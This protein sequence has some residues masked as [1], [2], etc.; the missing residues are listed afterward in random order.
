MYYFRKDLV[1]GSEVITQEGKA[2][3]NYIDTIGKCCEVETYE[4]IEEDDIY[5]YTGH[6]LM[7]FSDI[8]NQA[9]VYGNQAIFYQGFY[10]LL[11]EIA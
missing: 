5:K 7:S 2:I 3:V 1:V 4:Y 8:A 10:L 11:W 6:T 9:R